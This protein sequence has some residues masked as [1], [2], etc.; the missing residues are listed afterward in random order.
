MTVKK[1]Y[2]C[3]EQKELSEFHKNKRQ[4]DGFQ[5]YCKACAK[6][7]N[8]E[9]YLSTPH[10]NPQRRKSNDEARARSREFIWD[11]LLKHPCVDCGYANPVALEFDHV[12]GTKVSS[13]SAM[14]SRGIIPESLM[15][16]INK[17]EVRCA[18]CHR[19]VTAKRG[20]WWSK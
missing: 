15:E 18:N 11:Y 2:K 12:R 17:C 3:K 4:S 7:R 16:E 8:R 9:Y 1:C 14:S 10:R 6:T 19:I 20:G 5:N 13:I